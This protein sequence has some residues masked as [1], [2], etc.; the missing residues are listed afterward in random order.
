MRKALF[1]VILAMIGI[2]V[3]QLRGQ[4]NSAKDLKGPYLGQ[5]PPGMTPEV[6]APGTVSTPAYEH[7]APAFS[8]D[9][10][11]LYWS[12]F[13]EKEFKQKIF[14]MRLENGKWSEPAPAA[15]SDEKYLDGNPVFSRDGNR[16]YF[17]SNRPLNGNG[18][19]RD[20]YLWV[21]FAERTNGGWSEPIPLKAVFD[22]VGLAGAPSID[23]V[24]TLYF[25]PWQG[26]GLISGHIYSSALHNGAY[27]KPE[28]L[29]SEIN[30]EKY[31]AYSY[32][33]ADGRFI[34]FESQRTG[35]YGSDDLYISFKRNDGGW[36][37]A[38]NMGKAINSEFSDRCPTVSPDGKYLFF[39]SN[40]S[41]NYDYYWVN[42][43]IIETFISKNN[44]F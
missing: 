25:T 17:T 26:G 40:R 27:Q 38:I 41:G 7:G 42:A 15:F 22:Q 36:M 44:K 12:I 29:G 28:V 37:E 30:A 24:G 11:E 1:L 34:I 3:A 32:V 6:F 8:P 23:E 21:W 39:L 4:D 5:K 43:K 10:N 2:G 20:K 19:A 31:Q 16:L 13:Y 14:F 35:S 9:G 33:P 18:E